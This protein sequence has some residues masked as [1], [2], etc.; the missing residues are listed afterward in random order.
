MPSPAIAL[1]LT[2]HELM[3]GD[4]VD[5]NSALISRHLLETGILVAEKCTVG[6]EP[7]ALKKSLLR[8]SQEYDGVIINGGLG[9]TEDDLTASIIAD[10]CKAPLVK[11]PEAL[12]HVEAWCERRGIQANSANLKQ[13]WLPENADLIPNP[14]GSAVGFSLS[15]GNCLLLTTPGVPSELEAMLP[16]VTAM[17]VAAVGG[18]ETYIQR[19]QTFGVGE[20]TVQQWANELGDDWP[21]SVTLGFRAGVPQ[22]ELKLTVAHA[23]HV[24]EQKRAYELL[25]T[26]FGDHILGE[27]DARLAQVVQSLLRDQ[28][29]TVTTAESCTGGLIASMLTREPG[30]SSVFDAGFVTYANSAKNQ[31]LGVGEDT[32]NT[33]GAVSEPVVRQM[34]LGALERAG[35]DIGVAVSGIA[36]PDGGTADK[37]VGTV[38]IAWGTREDLRTHC[39]RI[40]GSRFLFQGLV[41]AVALDLIRRHLLGLPA[42]PHYFTRQ[43]Q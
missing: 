39:A 41:A 25:A 20:S 9:P 27:K 33:D 2:G 3:T 6:D 30:S 19:I 17:L 32:L 1:L 42:L 16:T 37:P 31:L 23:E 29:K 12:A 34:L 7:D 36:G 15:L 40:P 4:T 22:L 5:T 18:S 24:P 21:S 14:I 26:R 38:W 28:K 43:A 35:A 8:L 13:A 11:H 10:L